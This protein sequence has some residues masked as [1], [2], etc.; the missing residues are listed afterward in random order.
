MTQ[1]SSQKLLHFNG[2]DWCIFELKFAASLSKAKLTWVLLCADLNKPEDKAMGEELKKAYLSSFPADQQTGKI[3]EAQNEVHSSLVMSCIDALKT[4]VAGV[5]ATTKDCGT[6]LWNRLLRKYLPTIG[7]SRVR[8]TLEIFE[9]CTKFKTVLDSGGDTEDYFSAIEQSVR[10]LLA[11]GPPP[12]LE[13]IVSVLI[14]QAISKAG[15]MWETTATTLSDIPP[16][17]DRLDNIQ[18]R[19][20]ERFITFNAG[21]GNEPAK[22]PVAHHADYPAVP[23]LSFVQNGNGTLYRIDATGQV[24]PDYFEAQAVLFTAPSPSGS[25][26]G[27]ANPAGGPKKGGRERK[28]CDNCPRLSNHWTSECFKSQGGEGQSN[29]KGEK[30]LKCNRCL[31]EGHVSPECRAAAP[32]PSVLNKSRN[33]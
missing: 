22:G 28:K 10:N 27:S 29:E 5:P 11:S 9:K 25:P 19:V 6:A 4:L 3:L 17:E 24:F 1:V 30:K 16:G 33:K 20:R 12:T 18:E 7:A 31:E 23:G 32:H 2:V 26:L 21:S 15:T 13:D 14:I 8:M